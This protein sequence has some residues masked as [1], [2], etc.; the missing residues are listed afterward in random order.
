MIETPFRAPHRLLLL[1]GILLAFAAVSVA[2]NA[3][4]ESKPEYWKVFIS[5]EGR[6]SA[7]FPGSPSVTT[8][9]LNSPG[10][11]LLITNHFL[12]I[13]CLFAVSYADYPTKFENEKSTKEFLNNHVK[14][15]VDL[16]NAELLDNTEITLE[17]N[18]GRSIKTRM[19]TGAISRLQMYMVGQ[20]LYQ[21]SITSL[22]PSTTSDEADFGSD[23][24]QFFALFKL[25]TA[26][27]IVG[28]VDRWINENGGKEPLYGA[29]VTSDC[30]TEE[31]DKK[32][33][34]GRSIALPKPAYH[35]IARALKA[36]GT[37]K[38]QVII[39][40]TGRVIAAQPIN[41]HPIL[42]GASIIAAKGSRFTEPKYDG[43]PAKVIGVISYNFVEP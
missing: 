26:A 40:E 27:E 43:Q 18:A 31:I 29:C 37:V 1:P 28:E 24:L 13:R 34:G 23:S 9:A 6:F 14:G 20:R 42:F 5:H 12:Q 16:A 4:V 32:I 3:V 39:D 21:V 11:K 35:A 15:V 22:P 17:G 30:S 8:E 36:S 33:Q 41:G 19:P 10:G 25:I 38:V 2:Q 7:Y